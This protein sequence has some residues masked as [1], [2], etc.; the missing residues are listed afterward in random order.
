MTV[1]E[2]LDFFRA[3]ERV[4]R[5]APARAGEGGH[6]FLRTSCRSATDDQQ[7][8]E[9]HG[10]APV[11]SA[12]RCCTI[13]TCSFSTNRPRGWA[14]RRASSSS[15]SCACSRRRARRSSSARTFFPNSGDVRHA[16]LHRRGRIVHHGTPE[17]LERHPS[18]EAVFEVQVLGDPAALASW[19]ALNPGVRLLEERRAGARL[20]F[21]ESEPRPPPRSFA[22]WFS[23]AC[24]SSISTVSRAGS[25]MP[26]WTC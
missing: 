14:R 10:P 21:D 12:A 24:R 18:A 13:P 20:A 9:G 23:T 2:Y 19:V 22:K 11:A 7:A 5:R 16:A 15:S 3:R 25:R 1:F 6:D 26:S 17:S 8:L 4:A